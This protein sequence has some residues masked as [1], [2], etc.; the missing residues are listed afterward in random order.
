M[1]IGI[2]LF[3]EICDF[4]TVPSPV[5]SC[6]SYFTYLPRPYSGR[7]WHDEDGGGGSGGRGG[8]TSINEFLRRG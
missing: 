1:L 3:I 4:I 8:I 5:L 6:F 7:K 2:V